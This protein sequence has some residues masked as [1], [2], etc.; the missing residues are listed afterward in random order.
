VTATFD[1]IDALARSLHEARIRYCW[2]KGLWDSRLA[3]EPW[4]TNRHIGSENQPW[5][6]IAIAQ[7][8]AALEFLEAGDA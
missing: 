1:K 5:H 4:G 2:P 6:D 7:A 3:K 8:K